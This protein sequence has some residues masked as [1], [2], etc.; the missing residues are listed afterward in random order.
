MNLPHLRSLL[1]TM[2]ATNAAV[3]VD[4]RAKRALGWLGQDARKFLRLIAKAEKDVRDGIRGATIMLQVYG[5]EPA[6]LD[7]VNQAERTRALGAVRGDRR[8]AA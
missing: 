3:E 6:I 5:G 4:D 1:E 7:I 8:A 2:L